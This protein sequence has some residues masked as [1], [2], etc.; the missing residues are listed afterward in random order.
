MQSLKEFSKYSNIRLSAELSKAVD[1]NAISLGISEAQ[2]MENSGSAVAEFV[3]NINKS[4]KK[5][6][7]FCGIGGNGGDGM[8]CARHLAT[9]FD[10]NIILIGSEEQIVNQTTLLNY[11]ILKHL[12]TISFKNVDEALDLIK[13][14]D[15]IIID[16]I[17]G[18]GFHGRVN[19]NTKKLILKLNE[20]KNNLNRM[21]I[22]VDVPSG[23][24]I[25]ERKNHNAVNADYTITFYKMKDFLSECKNAGKIIVRD[26]GIPIDAELLTG[27]GDIFLA[28]KEKSINS[29]KY[30]N[31]SV[32]IIGGNAVYHGAPISAA[33]STQNA[34]ASLRTSIG[35]V[36][37]LLP[38]NIENIARSLSKNLIIQTFDNKLSISDIKRIDNIKHNVTIIGPGLD[39]DEHTLKIISKIIETEI[40]KKRKVIVD[41]AAIRIFNKYIKNKSSNKIF[42]NIILTPH[43]GE[44]QLLVNKN[45][46]NISLNERINLAIS[47]AK[48][49][50]ATIILKG[51]TTIITNGKLLKINFAETPTLAT[52]GSGDVLDGIIAAYLANG[53]DPFRSATAAVYLHSKIG[54]ELF[55]LK[56][57]H[58]IADDIIDMI[59][60]ILKKYDKIKY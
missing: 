9:Y 1:L 45:L 33:T 58:I 23:V 4:N 47:T 34:I 41:A 19:K 13:N 36:T 17:Y 55:K 59:P 18:I 53:V 60:Q 42:E 6:F 50:N 40:S 14:Y 29:N 37:L 54:D 38:K 20:L 24:S 2:M 46:K 27:D 30:T 3:K 49:L 56:G 8:V 48:K 44:F 43:L 12:K 16:A 32:L 25:S 11:R 7:V 57:M 5:I 15:S 39:T 10:T 51:N 28:T 52:M 22:S 26:I 21:V 31:G 35:Y